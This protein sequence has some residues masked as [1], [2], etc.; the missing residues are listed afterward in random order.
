MRFTGKTAVVTG[1]AQGIGRAVAI[2]LAMEDA[3]VVAIDINADGLL[4]LHEELAAYKSEN[5]F[6]C[7]ECD[8]SD[9]NAVKQTAQT[10]YV[11]M[12]E[13]E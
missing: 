11:F 10:Q 13:Q 6:L 7:L 4:R 2:K 5:D 3:R 8:I 12:E 1:A 9:E